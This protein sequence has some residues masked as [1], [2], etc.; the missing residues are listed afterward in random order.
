M[1][2]ITPSDVLWKSDPRLRNDPEPTLHSLDV[3]DLYF[4]PCE[5]GFSREVFEIPYPELNFSLDV[6][7]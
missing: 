7:A 6:R 5:L 3:F 1:P 2:V 4:S